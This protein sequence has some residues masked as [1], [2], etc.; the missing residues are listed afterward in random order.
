[1]SFDLLGELGKGNTGV[2]RLL[3]NDLDEEHFRKLMSVAAVD[4]VDPNVFIRSL[5]LSLE[6]I[7][8]GERLMPL[9]LDP[10]LASRHQP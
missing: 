2:V 9:Y 1:M 4:L 7:S 8:A 3:V 5:L 6:R 10:C